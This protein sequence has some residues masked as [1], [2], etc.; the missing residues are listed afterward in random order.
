MF[1]AF[2]IVYLFLGGLGS[3]MLLLS[4][5]SSLAFHRSLNRSELETRAFDAW[6]N[7]CFVW[8]FVVLTC[9]ALCLMLDLGRPERF[10]MLFLRPSASSVLSYGAIFLAALIAVAAF[11][12]VANYCGGR[13]RVPT[14]ARKA[15]EVACLV[16]S[17]LVMAYTGVYLM[18]TQAVSFW[19]TPLIVALFV[20][21]A[22]SMGLSGCNM[23]GSLLRDTW[24]LDGLTDGLHWTHVVVLAIEVGVLAWFLADAMARGGRAA[25][26]CALLFSGELEVWFFG[27]VVMC[28]LAI[29]FIR[30]VV[31]LTAAQIASFPVSDVLCVF[32][33]LALRLCLVSAGLH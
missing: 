31:P 7:R 15:S 25:D 26:S 10:V 24:M 28:G 27:G 13:V 12:L 2:V 33:G 8:G 6:R 14:G 29:P 22:V 11:L 1:G 3:G 4:S 19:S 30:G 18:S 16:L 21:S 23:A 5:A 32:G 9:G 17:V 20:A